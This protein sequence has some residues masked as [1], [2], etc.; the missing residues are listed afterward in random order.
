MKKLVSLLLCLAMLLSLT[1][2]F[3]EVNHPDYINYDSCL[4]IIKEGSDGEKIT[5]KV[6]SPRTRLAA[7]GTICG[8]RSSSK[9]TGTL[10][11]K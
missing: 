2:A 11:W 5:L 1:S 10:I 6:R 8:L 7:N 4:P 3:A 9:S